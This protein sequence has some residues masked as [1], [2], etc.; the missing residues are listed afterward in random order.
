MN[1]DK[2]S[3]D[4]FSDRVTDYVRYRPSYPIGALEAIRSIGELRARSSPID[5][6]EVSI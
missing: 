6:I 4:R 2:D 1:V 5:R 3:V